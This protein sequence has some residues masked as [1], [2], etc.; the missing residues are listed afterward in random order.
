M[1]NIKL[2]FKIFYEIN[3]YRLLFYRLITNT[4]FKE[5]LVVANSYP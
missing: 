4:E 1:L 3:C 2:K 5:T